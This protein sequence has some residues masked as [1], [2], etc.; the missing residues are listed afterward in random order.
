MGNAYDI[1]CTQVL[2]NFW[3]H[4]QG[5]EKQNTIPRNTNVFFGAV[6]ACPA[7]SSHHHL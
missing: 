2:G 6:M 1:R 5:H 4:A 7:H 3:S